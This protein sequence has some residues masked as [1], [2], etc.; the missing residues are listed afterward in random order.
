MF[1]LRCRFVFCAHC[2]I[3]L[4]TTILIA[5]PANA[6]FTLFS[7]GGNSTTA[8]IQPTVDAFR[9]VLGN[10]NNGNNPGPLASGRREINWDGG[11]A[12]VATPVGTPMTTFQNTR[13]GTFVTPGT[14]FL[15]TP[16]NDAA[17]TSINA[18]YATTFGAFSPVRIFTP[19]G[20]NITDATFS[21]PGTN[22]ATPATVS[23]FGA[24]FSDVDMPGATS[25]QFFDSGNNL[26]T[27]IAVP[28]GS[29]PDGSLS[30]AGAIA[31]AGEQIAR[32]RIV[33]GNSALGP[34]DS[35]GNPIDVVVMDDFLYS[36]PIPEPTSL[37]ILLP[38]LLACGWRRARR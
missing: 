35:N 17:L 1:K 27:S 11:G 24:I 38:G 5:V 26:L 13:G 19:L 14:G 20:S 32:V 4:L 3:S 22:G 18:S 36:E 2:I 31:N 25:M 37:A 8:S 6:G 23:G 9:A 21:I 15:Q 29:V 10:P 30:F 28:T 7:V 16:V 12:V 34:S 33:T